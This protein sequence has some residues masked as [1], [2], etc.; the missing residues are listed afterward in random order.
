MKE[1]KLPFEINT[2]EYGEKITEWVEQRE[3]GALRV[4]FNSFYSPVQGDYLM[5]SFRAET[6]GVSL[7]IMEDADVGTWE[8]PYTTANVFINFQNI[9]KVSLDEGRTSDIVK[10]NEW[11]KIRYNDLL[12]TLMEPKD[13]A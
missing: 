1:I 12:L 11:I 13:Q 10:Y 7:H 4:V 3:G 6:D 8:E 2:T 5:K 9:Q